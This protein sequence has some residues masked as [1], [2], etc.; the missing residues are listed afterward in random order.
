MLA[1]QSTKEIL[2]V[3]TSCYDDPHGASGRAVAPVAR[4][5]G[6][7][8]DVAGAVGKTLVVDKPAAGG[9]T[10]VVEA[11]DAD[12]AAAPVERRD[13]ASCASVAKGAA[14]AVACAVGRYDGS[15][16]AFCSGGRWWVGVSTGA[17]GTETRPSAGPDTAVPQA[18]QN[19]PAGVGAPQ[20]GHCGW[21]MTWLA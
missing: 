18:A 6:S 8:P 11:A 3:R 17:A 21:L 5:G 7:T 20:K 10:V 15:V 2:A 1:A 19:R 4:C 16:G 13:G 9:D 12:V 14:V